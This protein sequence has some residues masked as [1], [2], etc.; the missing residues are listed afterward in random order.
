MWKRSIDPAQKP[1]LEKLQR[2]IAK[3]ESTG[4]VSFTTRRAQA[5]PASA[6][7]RHVDTFMEQSNILHAGWMVPGYV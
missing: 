3:A 2:L 7:P 6:D 4:L 5:P 1:V